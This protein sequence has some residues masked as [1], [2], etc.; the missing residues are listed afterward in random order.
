[1]FEVKEMNFVNNASK[2]FFNCIYKKEVNLDT[3]LST[4]NQES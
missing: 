3:L 4:N 2:L 1:M